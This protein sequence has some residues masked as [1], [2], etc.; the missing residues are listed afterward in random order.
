VKRPQERSLVWQAQKNNFEEYLFKK[1]K[2]FKDNCLTNLAGL[3]L[4]ARGDASRVVQGQPR[5]ITYTYFADPRFFI[6]YPLSRSGSGF[7]RV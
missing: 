6:G 7:D 4:S 5:S 2:E 3:N 1:I